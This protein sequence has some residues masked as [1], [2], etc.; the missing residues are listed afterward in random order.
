MI[1][2]LLVDDHE[3][4][5]AGLK[6]LL[7]DVRS[8]KVVAEAESGEEALGLVQE[9]DD[10]D[11][12]LM[13]IGMPGIGGMEATRRIV[14]CRPMVKVIVVTIHAEEPLPS[15]LLEA[16]ASGY[17]TK[18]SDFEEIIYAIK[19][20][21]KGK[22]YIGNEVAQHIAFSK[23][24][25]TE[26]SPIQELSDREIQVLMMIIRGQSTQ[27]ISDNLCLSPKTVSTYRSRLYEKLGVENDVEL[28]LLAT[29]FG[30]AEKKSE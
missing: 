1:N 26:H 8:M 30:L 29:R 5:R 20:V 3:L 6:R 22:R 19:R 14:R 24:P 27:D 28:T 25:G 18:G 21:T 23:L 13:D 4:V 11:V 16:G 10:I 15:K 9:R 12:V 17:L 2:I 7:K